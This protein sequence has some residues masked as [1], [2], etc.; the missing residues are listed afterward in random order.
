MKKILA[1]SLTFL[2]AI[3]SITFISCGQKTARS[4]YEI[5]CKLVDNLIEGKEKVTF[6]NHTEN[7]F[8][9]L[10]FNLFANAFRKDA[11]YKPIAEQYYNRAYYLGESYGDIKILKAYDQKGELEFNIVG[12]DQNILEVNLN[13]EIFPEESV[14]IF[15]EY[16]ITLANVIARTGIGKNAV[17]LAN[18]YPV[19]C[20][21]SDGAFYECVYYANGDPYFSDCADYLYTFSCSEEYI[22]A[23]SGEIVKSEVNS[24]V[25]TNVYKI[26]NARSICM[27]LS[28]DFEILSEKVD[29]VEINYYFYNDSLATRSLQTAKKSIQYF[30]NTFGEYP[31]KKYSVVQ[32]EFIQ[33]GMEFPALVM[34]SDQ[35]EESAYNEVIVHETAHQWWQTAVG[36]NEIEYGFLDEGLTEY[37]VILFY[38][39]H[40]EYSLTREALINQSEKTY[41]LFCSVYDKLFLKVDTSMLRSL[42]DFSSEYEYVNIA[43]IKPCIMLDN[44]RITIGEEKFFSSLKDY[45]EEYKF[46]NA[47][48]DDLVSRFENR[49]GEVHKYFESFF[50]GK[51]V[52]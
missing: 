25:Q 4:S 44:L 49:V 37:S 33:G 11:K 41:K 13:K 26:E 22:V 19:L 46:K 24:G 15:I 1:L 45:Y 29:G 51:E 21:I 3:C 52:I 43:Y 8:N 39:N 35:L 7:S 23:S 47:T 14:T 10:K 40:P 20:G 2:L 17:N 27:V 30:E 16:T 48:P 42:K 38:E 36:N 9:S 12:E 31:Y 50:E 5:E 28:K 32:T 18:F 6:Y 34:I